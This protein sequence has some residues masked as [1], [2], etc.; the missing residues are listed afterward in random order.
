MNSLSV[1]VCTL[2]FITHNGFEP[3]M[4]VYLY[5][6][7]NIQELFIHTRTL[8]Y[9]IIQKR[10]S[11]FLYDRVAYFISKVY[12]ENHVKSLNCSHMCKESK[13]LSWKQ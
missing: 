6:E 4:F 7:N 11:Q 13:L 8:E 3:S 5:K 2:V 12:S 10:D 1:I 9:F